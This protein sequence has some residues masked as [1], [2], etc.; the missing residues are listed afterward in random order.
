MSCPWRLLGTKKKCD[1]FQNLEGKSQHFVLSV[2][3]SQ[4]IVDGIP[5][6]IRLLV[7][8]SVHEQN[9]FFI[10]LMGHRF[11]VAGN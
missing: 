2:A 6:C 11:G 10:R 1:Q 4:T 9:N 3:C 5:M 8:L 7:A